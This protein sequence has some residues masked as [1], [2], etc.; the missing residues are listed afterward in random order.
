M[1][2]IKSIIFLLC[3]TVFSA[4]G[5]EVTE[6]VSFAYHLS[7][8][9]AV[10]YV[11]E[12]C[13][14]YD[15]GEI[16]CKKDS[17][18]NID[19]SLSDIFPFTYKIDNNWFVGRRCY[20]YNNVEKCNIDSIL[21]Y[22]PIKYFNHKDKP[23]KEDTLTVV[24]YS[25]I[26]YEIGEPKIYGTNKN[27][28]ILRFIWMSENEVDIYYLVN[29]QSEISLNYKKVIL[30]ENTEVVND[31]TLVISSI[32]YDK[33]LKILQKGRLWEIDENVK[34]SPRN[35]L[36]ETFLDGQYFFLNKNSKEIEMTNK[37][38]LKVYPLL[39]DLLAN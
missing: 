23:A 19:H 30:N 39:K 4:F 36:I 26:L 6:I 35:I 15:N 29:K 33:V 1:R 11:I 16:R 37:V 7:Y 10:W 31:T 27:D 21:I 20:R 18:L 2:K 9:D 28:D 24:D 14:K 5:Q 38:L 17:I 25:T 3:C 13:F 34:I 22:T 32:N 12:P 8:N